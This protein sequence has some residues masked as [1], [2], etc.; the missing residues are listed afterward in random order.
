MMQTQRLLWIAKAKPAF[1]RGF[2]RGR[3]LLKSGVAK[4]RMP[5]VRSQEEEFLLRNGRLEKSNRP[6][7]NQLSFEN[8][9]SIYQRN[10]YHF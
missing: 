3:Q 8:R 7:F 2:L 4:G 10:F 6:W 5:F 1:A 9:I